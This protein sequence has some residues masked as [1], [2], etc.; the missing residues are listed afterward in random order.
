MLEGGGAEAQGKGCTQPGS[1]D[2]QKP[3]SGS[4]RLFS[5]ALVVFRPVLGTQARGSRLSMPGQTGG[6][7]NLPPGVEA[8]GLPVHISKESHNHR[9]QS[10]HGKTGQDSGTH[11]HL[12]LCPIGSTTLLKC[13][14]LVSSYDSW[15]GSWGYLGSRGGWGGGPWGGGVK[16]IRKTESYKHILSTGFGFLGA[17]SSLFQFRAKA[18][19]FPTGVTP[20][21]GHALQTGVWVSSQEWDTETAFLMCPSILMAPEAYTL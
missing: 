15:E 10:R 13:N 7:K 21:K 17:V 11:C 18:Q 8:L 14:G 6:S 1:P 5:P 16:P 9:P 3:S 2:S 4:R 19:V 12:H 20:N